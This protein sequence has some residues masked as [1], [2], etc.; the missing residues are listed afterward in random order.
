MAKRRAGSPGVRVDR[1][2]DRLYLEPEEDPLP[3]AVT[4][5]SSR[6]M[7]KIRDESHRF[8]LEYHRWLRRNRNLKSVLDEIPGIGPARK[9]ALLRAFGSLK[10][11]RGADVDQLSR[12]RTMDRPTAS[13]LYEFLREVDPAERQE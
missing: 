4:R 7:V 6:L 11:L 3:L 10:A 13:V 2:L 8:A 9:K 1:S 12:V 5:R